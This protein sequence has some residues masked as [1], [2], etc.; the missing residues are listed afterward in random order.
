VLL[1]AEILN[2]YCDDIFCIKVVYGWHCFRVVTVLIFL[3]V[4]F[5]SKG[6]RIVQA[7]SG[8]DSNSESRRQSAKQE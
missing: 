6:A 2:S 4:I 1:I 3:C 5:V 8:S 7:D